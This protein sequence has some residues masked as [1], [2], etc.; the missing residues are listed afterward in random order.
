MKNRILENG[1]IANL[2]EFKL[3]QASRMITNYRSAMQGH[4]DTEA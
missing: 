4:N 3:N 1:A 2:Q